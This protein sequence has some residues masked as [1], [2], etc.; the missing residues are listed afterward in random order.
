MEVKH[1]NLIIDR[2]EDIATNNAEYHS[3]CA[4]TDVRLHQY[5]AGKLLLFVDNHIFQEHKP[6]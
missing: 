1:A 5:F 2:M 3:V 4:I 6:A